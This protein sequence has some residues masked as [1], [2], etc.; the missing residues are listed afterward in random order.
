M[1]KLGTRSM[2]SQDGGANWRN[3]GDWGA[4]IIQGHTEGRRFGGDLGGQE[5]PTQ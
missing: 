2:G 1:L 4:R 3:W 5:G